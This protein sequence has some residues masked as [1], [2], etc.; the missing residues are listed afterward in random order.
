MSSEHH[1]ETHTEL[2]KANIEQISVLCTVGA[3]NQA[4]F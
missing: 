2:L 4:E 3:L 1:F